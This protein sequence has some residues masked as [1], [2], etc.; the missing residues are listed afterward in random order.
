M[1]GLPAGE[2]HKHGGNTMSRS[3]CAFFLTVVCGPAFAAAPSAVV[4]GVSSPEIGVNFLDFL[5]PGTT[6]T[7]GAAGTLELGYLNSCIHEQI[8]GGK[9]T[10]GA[11][12]SLVEG[13]TVDRKTVR[14][15]G[16]S[17]AMA[18]DEA[19]QSGAVAVRK[20]PFGKPEAKLVVHHRSPY[21]L[22]PKAGTVIVQ[23]LE[24]GS[25]RHELPSQGDGER[26]YLDLV[27]AG[28]SLEAGVAYEV[29]VAGQ[30]RGFRVAADAD[31]GPA[32]LVARVVPF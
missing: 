32:P 18:A 6:V 10:V 14:C 19:T 4:E 13:G 17:L 26:H 31:D 25:E 27:Q 7:L 29:L 20:L 21:I 24:D 9:V 15:D 3:I 2:L 12:Q 1:L 16:G 23:R 5:P 11:E 8:R 22:L 28:V 30:A